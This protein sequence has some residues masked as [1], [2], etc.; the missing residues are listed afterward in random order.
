MLK[1]ISL[2]SGIGGLDFGF[3]EAGFETRVALELDKFACRTMRLNR[4]SWEVI[5]GDV[6]AVPSSVIL[7]KG[8]LSVGE[9]DVLIGG[10][11]CQPFSKSSYWVRGDSLRL[12][13][14]RADTL[15]GYLRVLR[16]TQ[17]KAF[18]LENVGGLAYEGK[19]E[20]LQV[21][22]DGIRQVNQATGTRY[23][24][25]WRVVRCAEYGVPQ[26]RE[27][28]F[29]VGARDGRQFRFPEPTHGEAVGDM[30]SPT[31][32]PFMTAW[33]ALGDIAEPNSLDGLRIGG[34]WGELLPTIPEGQN[35]LWHTPRGGG[36]PLFGWRTRYWSFLLKLSKR[37]PSWTVQAQPGSAIGPF[38]WKNRRMTFHEMCA[39]QTFPK[40]LIMHE[41][42]TEMQRMLG[43]A[44]PSLIAEILA[45]EIRKQILDVPAKGRLALKPKRKEFVPPPERLAPVPDR[46]HELVA[47]HAEHPGTGKGRNASKRVQ[48]AE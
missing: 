4:P 18:L 44:V 32:E 46:Y 43:N 30:F 37:L 1:T 3:E 8:R 23:E 48:A 24:P 45:R 36:M 7:E 9:A 39:I 47:N 13:D 42:R 21:L 33:D 22:L 15:A 31:R 6:N 16:D 28:V 10:P 35:Y 29:L 11:P 27:R 26:I 12:D 38:H 19:D 17:P 40:G 41:G 25:A 14:P 20:G 34:K 5:E 2:F